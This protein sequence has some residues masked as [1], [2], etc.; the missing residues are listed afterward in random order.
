M[1]LLLLSQAFI[2]V[3]N[4]LFHSFDNLITIQWQH[5]ISSDSD[6]SVLK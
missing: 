6:T 1:I 3:L 4:F 5:T 2:L